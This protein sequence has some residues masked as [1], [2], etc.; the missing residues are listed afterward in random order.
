MLIF[1]CLAGCKT[2]KVIEYQTIE[3]PRIE[4]HYANTISRDTVFK[5]DSV[6]IYMLGDTIYHEKVHNYYWSSVSHD[7]V[8]HNDTIT[9]IVDK[10]IYIT[11]EVEKKLSL[12]ESITMGIGYITLF[13]LGG[14]GVIFLIKKIKK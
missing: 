2:G 12:F 4:H 14:S 11:K 6:R 13:I 1:L 5:Q 8:H 10:P 3:V 9:R 7:T